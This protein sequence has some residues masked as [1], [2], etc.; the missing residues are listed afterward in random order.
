[1][2]FLEEMFLLLKMN[3]KYDEMLTKFV[4]IVL[5]IVL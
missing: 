2:L 4:K 3:K 5:F 1:M